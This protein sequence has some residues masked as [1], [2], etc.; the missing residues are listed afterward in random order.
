MNISDFVTNYGL[1]RKVGTDQAAL[2]DQQ[3]YDKQVHALGIQRQQAENDLIPEAQAAARARYG[4]TTAQ[5]TSTTG[6]V[7]AVAENTN[8]QL[9]TFLGRQNDILRSEANAAKTAASESGVRMENLP[10]HLNFMRQSNL[11]DDQKQGM[12]MLGGLAYSI[13][14]GDQ[15]KAV[16]YANRALKIHPIPG[17]ESATVAS[18][19]P[20]VPGPDG[21]PSGMLRMLDAQGSTVMDI[22]HASI[23][24]G[25]NMLTPPVLKEIAKGGMLAK[26][27]TVTGTATEV[28]SNPEA[29]RFDVKDG[30]YF[31]RQG[32]QSPKKIEGAS[33]HD[34]LLINDGVEQLALDFGAK[35][36]PASKMLDTSAIKDPEGFAAARA[37]LAARV[38]KGE[39]PMAVAKD[40]SNRYRKSQATKDAIGTPSGDYTGPAPWKR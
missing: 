32:K 19:V 28:L 4:L 36:D 5:D 23:Q 30:I 9:P 10:N 13:A 17:K 8:T 1:V 37:E 40:L 18:I 11:I 22:P 24:A 14:G 25:Y 2:E 33:P 12:L 31:D 20:D 26:V 27:N 16:D 3:N 29:D 38:G 34:R 21:K 6:F 7:Q 39:E 35:L 15:Q